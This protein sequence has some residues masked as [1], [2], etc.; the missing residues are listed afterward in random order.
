MVNGEIERLVNARLKTILRS[1]ELLAPSE[2]KFRCFRGIVLD[3]LG[4]QGLIA[5][6]ERLSGRWEWKGTGRNTLGK[7][8]GGP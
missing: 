8:G 3:E 4:E 7:E 6:L 2:E 5:D 1:A